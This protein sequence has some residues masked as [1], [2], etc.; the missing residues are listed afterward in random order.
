MRIMLVLGLSAMVWDAAAAPDANRAKI[1][2]TC[3]EYALEDKVAADEMDSYIQQCVQD[4]LEIRSQ[5]DTLPK[6]GD[7]PVPPA[8]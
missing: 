8:E 4:L 7:V 5:E 2:Q 6:E 3:K 1:E